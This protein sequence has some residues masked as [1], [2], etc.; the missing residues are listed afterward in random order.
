MKVELKEQSEEQIQE[1]IKLNNIL[2]AIINLPLQ[3]RLDEELPD[4]DKVKCY[5]LGYE[6]AFT[7]IRNVI[8]QAKSNKG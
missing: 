4:G 2:N 7:D 6:D 8:D 3:S 5:E 1:M